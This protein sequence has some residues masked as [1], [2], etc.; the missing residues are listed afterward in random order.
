M[1]T[2]FMPS[3]RVPSEAERPF[4]IS[5]ADLMT[6]MMMLFLATVAV[7]IIVATKK[8]EVQ[9]NREAQHVEATRKLCAQIKQDVGPSSLIDVDCETFQINFGE[10]GRFANR[11]YHLPA[12]AN[13][14]LADLVPIILRHAADESSGQLLKQ[15]EIEG[16]ASPIGTYLD[17]LHLSM[18]RSEWVMCL[19]ID[20]RKNTAIQLTPEQLQR[21]RELFL[22][23]GVSFNSA[24]QTDA[25][26]RRVELKLK[27]LDLDEPREPRHR[28]A[29]VSMAPDRCNL[30]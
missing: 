27:F 8:V 24:K 7:T 23:G 1:P 2:G 16:Y 15:V 17:N 10:A 3:K 9:L 26:S 4:W 21:V 30:P 13:Q 25:E 5:Y 20:S 28:V 19:L 18:Q 11:D 6:A 14:A 12:G 22:A 29:N